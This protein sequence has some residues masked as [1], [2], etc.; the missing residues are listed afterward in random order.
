MKDS[1]WF[2]RG[3]TLEEL[4]AP[5]NVRFFNRQW[6]TLGTKQTLDRVLIQKTGIDDDI[7]SGKHSLA[8]RSIAQRMSRASERKITRKED[9]A[10]CLLGIFDVNNMP[11]LYGEGGKKAILRLHEEIIKQSD[12]HTIFAWPI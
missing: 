2:T 11:L 12:D 5:P 9:R 4:L 10:Y 1:V 7:L 3:W 6:I 8:S